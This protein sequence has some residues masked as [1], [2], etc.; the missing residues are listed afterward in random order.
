[1]VRQFTGKKAQITVFMIIGIVIVIAA[2]IYFSVFFRR[3]EL[4]AEEE[5]AVEVPLEVKPIQDFVENCVQ[6]VG[7]EALKLAGQHGGYIYPL[8]T[9]LDGRSFSI[10]PD[11]PSSSDGVSFTGNPESAVIYWWYLKSPNNCRRCRITSENI[12]KIEMVELQVDRYVEDN[13]PA[14]IDGFRQFESEGFNVT[15]LGSPVAKTTVTE[16]DVVISLTFP[17]TAVLDERGTDLERFISHVPINLKRIY[18]LAEEIALSEG[19][20]NFLEYETNMWIATNSGL[21]TDQLPP[22]YAIE[23]SYAP[24]IW[25]YDAVKLQME[26]LLTSY[27]SSLQVNETKGAVPSGGGFGFGANDP[28]FLNLLREP[29]DEYSV[30]FFYL[31]WPVYLG[32]RPNQDGILGAARVT[33]IEMMVQGLAPFVP[34]V[35]QREYEFFY[36]ISYPVVVELR[37]NDDLF[38]GGFTWLF[39]LESN[40]RDNRG[41]KE[42]FE[43]NGTYGPWD[44]SWVTFNIPQEEIA[45]VEGAENNPLTQNYTKDLFCSPKQRLSGNLSIVVTDAMNGSALDGVSVKYSCGK[46]ASCMIGQTGFDFDN[47]MTGIIARFPVCVGGGII[48]LDKPGY[49]AET[50][51]DLTTLPHEGAEYS[52]EMVPLFSKS[53]SLVK[54]PLERVIIYREPLEDF[55]NNYTRF[56][57]IGTGTAASSGFENET[58]IVNIRK[59]DEIFPQSFAAQNLIIDENTGSRAV[60][61]TLA[62]G[63]YEVQTTYIDNSGIFIAP[64]K[65]CQDGD[66]N[67]M[68][69]PE[70]PGLSLDQVIGGGLVLDSQTGYWE[71]DYGDLE[72]GDTVVFRILRFPKPVVIDDLNEM[73]LAQNLSGEFRSFLQPRFI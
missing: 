7:T 13:L 35:P 43:G 68:F 41:V 47:N 49:K 51:I 25:V 18:S 38:G 73:S 62:P 8:E 19:N 54:V 39:A 22:T 21:H 5:P 36:D 37:N 72:S 52:F 15:E 26:S 28:F 12:P 30:R 10:D 1:M 50:I 17:L 40:I 32:I 6:K 45:M 57:D 31:G 42:W 2:I 58:I 59:V 53:V 4:T 11:D 34:M 64:E 44:Y 9:Q 63:M 55:G 29:Y 65:R 27:V 67:C 66:E 56:L 23:E 61:I 24:K 14:C 60:N 16:K 71:V 33:D 46:Y 69:I 3:G 48:T 70:A 20:N